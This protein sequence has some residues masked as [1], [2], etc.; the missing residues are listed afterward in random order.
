MH[1]SRTTTTR[2]Q[3]YT[4]RTVLPAEANTQLARRTCSAIFP[5]HRE[6][7]STLQ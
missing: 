7:A 6:M 3:T 2:A 5:R 4:F 1:V